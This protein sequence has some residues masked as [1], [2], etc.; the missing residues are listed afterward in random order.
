MVR[1]GEIPSNSLK[2]K[3]QP[4]AEYL[5]DDFFIPGFRGGTLKVT[6]GNGFFG[7]V[8]YKSLI[9][10]LSGQYYLDLRESS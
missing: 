10:K 6:A 5:T 2:P 8:L 7:I 9:R 4:V 1:E 3:R